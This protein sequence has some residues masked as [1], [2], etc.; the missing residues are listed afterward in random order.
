MRRKLIAHFIPIACITDF[1]RIMFGEIR[2]QSKVQCTSYFSLCHL[3]LSIFCEEN[4]LLS[5]FISLVRERVG[6]GGF[7]PSLFKGGSNAERAVLE[8][9]P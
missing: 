4:N 1:T 5:T 6:G 3:F 7:F 2:I 8:R 9:V